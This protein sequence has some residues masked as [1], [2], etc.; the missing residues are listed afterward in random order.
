M[1]QLYMIYP[2]FLTPNRLIFLKKATQSIVYAETKTHL[3]TVRASI[4]CVLS[5]RYKA[6][7]KRE[8]ENCKSVTRQR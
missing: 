8:K 6:G 1:S 4:R 2:L 7:V 5:G 3:M